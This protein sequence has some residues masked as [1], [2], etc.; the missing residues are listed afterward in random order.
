MISPYAL[1]LYSV[2]FVV[3][4]TNKQSRAI[5]LVGFVIGFVEAVAPFLG[6]K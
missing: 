2:L 1:M 5:G 6:Y 3:G 4:G